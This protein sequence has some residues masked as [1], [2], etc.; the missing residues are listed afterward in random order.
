MTN[1]ER[2]M[3][4]KETPPATGNENKDNQ[5]PTEYVKR[6]SL[7]RYPKAGKIVGRLVGDFHKI[8]THDLAPNKSLPIP[9][10]G[11][12]PEGSFGVRKGEIPYRV[13]C[14]NFD[15]A[16]ESKVN[17]DC[18]W[19]KIH[20]RAHDMAKWEKKDQK[21]KNTLSAVANATKQ[22]V[23]YYVNWIDRDDP[24]Y[25][26]KVKVDGKWE[27]KKVKGN[28][29]LALPK[30]AFDSIMTLMA[31][32]KKD[33]SDPDNG[34]DIEISKS[35]TKQETTY[36][37]SFVMDEEMSA[38]KTPLTEEERKYPIWN[39]SEYLYDKYDFKEIYPKLYQ[40]FRDVYE[41]PDEKFKEMKDAHR[42]DKDEG[43]TESET[44]A[45]ST[46][47]STTF[48]QPAEDLDPDAIPF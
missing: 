45:P 4:E 18:P 39:P 5:F 10:K 29:I 20:W 40:P 31:S 32:K 24:T 6:T 22:N 41:I 17:G 2:M 46:E 33:L 11:V 44:T 36:T 1:R 38:K 27:E 21:L 43:E 3:K 48:E 42:N 28:V 19:E 23:K 30:K 16:T 7:I 14:D 47:G 15:E 25:I 26:K 37:V 35:G 8:V 9:T 13:K 34:Y 12:A